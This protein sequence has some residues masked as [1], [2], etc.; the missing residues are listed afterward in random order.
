MRATVPTPFFPNM[1]CS[2]YV[3][4]LTNGTPQPPSALGRNNGS[5]WDLWSRRHVRGLRSPLSNRNIPLWCYPHYNIWYRHY[6]NDDTD[7]VTNL[8]KA[9]E[10]W[11]CLSL[12]LGRYGVDVRT[13]ERFYIAII[14]TTLIFGLETLFV[15]P[16]M[17]RILVGF[18]HWL[19]RQIMVKLL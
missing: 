1:A 5:A 6:E 4:Y 12:I 3:S 2:S 16:C 9:R 14:L 15:T 18:H 7:V 13:E 8:R 19:A 17:A 11:A 10:V